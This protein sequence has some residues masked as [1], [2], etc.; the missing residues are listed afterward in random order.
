MAKLIYDGGEV[1]LYRREG[2]KAE[3]MYIV[4]AGED[5][6][7]V[8]GQKVLTLALTVLDDLMQPKEELPECGGC[9]ASIKWMT[10]AAG[11]RTPVNPVPKSLLL[12]DGEYQVGYTS[13]FATC[14]EGDSFRRPR[15]AKKS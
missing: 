7:V 14:P 5:G 10:T 4:E 8:S 12:P 13:H 15:K 1:R 3:A 6:A 11:K 2:A 9:H